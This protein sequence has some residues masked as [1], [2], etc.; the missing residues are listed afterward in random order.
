MYLHLDPS[1]K[2]TDAVSRTGGEGQHRQRVPVLGLIGTEAL[3]VK[4]IR[5]LPKGGVPLDEVRRNIDFR[6]RGHE[7]V[8]QLIVFT[9]LRVISQPG[10]YKLIV[11]SMTWRV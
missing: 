6:S 9:A 4:A 1:E 2:L 5:I 10:G 11:S 7:I 8:A 3:R